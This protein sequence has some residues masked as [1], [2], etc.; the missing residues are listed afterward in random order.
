MSGLDLGGAPAKVINHQNFTINHVTNTTVINNTT[1]INNKTVNNVNTKGP[2]QVVSLHGHK[3]A[4]LPSLTE[5]APAT[6]RTPM[7]LSLQTGLPPAGA[8]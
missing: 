8:S 3:A 7:K 1:I 4:P 6:T 5:K 2:L